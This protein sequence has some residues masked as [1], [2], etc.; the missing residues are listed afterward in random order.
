MVW[1]TDEELI[2]E[3]HFYALS[4]ILREGRDMA[5]TSTAEMAERFLVT[6]LAPSGGKGDLILWRGPAG[7]H[8][9]FVGTEVVIDML[10]E[11]MHIW[12]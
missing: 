11:I 12:D 2:H 4:S 9:E 10:G 7:S 8:S 6:R 5:G 1:T 3:S